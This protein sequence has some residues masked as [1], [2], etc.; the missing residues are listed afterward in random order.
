MEYN[1]ITTTLIN[2]SMSLE[3]RNASLQ[4]F[5]TD[6]QMLISTD[7]GGEGLNLQCAHIVINYDLPWNP[8]KIEQRIGRADRIGQT[9]DVQV[10]NFILKGHHRKPRPHSAGGEA[11]G[12]PAGACIDKLQ[13]VLDEGTA[14]MD[15]TKAY[16]DSIVMPR[17][18]DLYVGEVEKNAQKQVDQFRHIQQVIHEDKT[19]VNDE[20]YE[21][22][23]HSFHVLLKEMLFD[24]RSWKGYDPDWRLDWELSLSDKQ[25]QG[26]SCPEADLASEPGYAADSFPESEDREWCV[27]P[28]EVSLGPEPADKNIISIFINEQGVY[29][30]AASRLIW[31]ELLKPECALETGGCA[32][33]RP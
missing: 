15:F 32:A 7:A 24:Y 31:E 20:D 1:G 26:H 5:R 18:Q 28:L 14:D 12:Y 9:D 27:L 2:G 4:Q 29:R 10:Y 11:G 6:K 23:Q 22:Q 3:E 8:M 33:C 17:F 13:D 30:P 16:I 21:R 19:L 25:I